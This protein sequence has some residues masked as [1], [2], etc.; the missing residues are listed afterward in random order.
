MTSSDHREQLVISY[1][2]ETDLHHEKNFAQMKFSVY[3]FYDECLR[4]YGNANVWRYYTDLFDF[5]PLTAIVDNQIFALH[6][7]LSVSLFVI[8]HFSN[9]ITLILAVY[10]YTGSYKSIGS[11][12]RSTSW[13]SHVRPLMVRSRRQRWMGNLTTWCWIHIWSGNNCK[14]TINNVLNYILGYFR[15]FQSHKWPYPDITCPSA[16]HGGLQLVSRQKRG[17]YFFCTKLLLQMWQ[18]GKIFH[19]KVYPQNLPPRFTLCI[20]RLP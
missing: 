6:G 12:S 15:N 7:G 17:Y 8:Y 19:P 11:S 18:P 2:F 13:G 4:K 14:N 10:R 1:L 9:A 16:G 5:L 3:G 20:F